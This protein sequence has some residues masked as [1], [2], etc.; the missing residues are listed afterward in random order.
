M[1]GIGIEWW[2]LYLLIFIFA[3]SICILLGF[4]TMGVHAACNAVE[5]CAIRS[6][7]IPNI[8]KLI[9]DNSGNFGAS[10]IDRKEIP[11]LVLEIRDNIDKKLSELEKLLSKIISILEVDQ[12]N[13]GEISKAV[14]DINSEV[15]RGIQFK[16]FK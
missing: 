5:T 14:S 13:R 10:K 8:Y 6:Y 15:S 3:I 12:G 2:I 1:F 9:L 7:D 11:G 16:F 4:L